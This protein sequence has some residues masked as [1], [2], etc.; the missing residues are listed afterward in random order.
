VERNSPGK[1][2]FHGTVDDLDL[3]FL[4]VD[5]RNAYGVP[6]NFLIDYV[7]KTE[8]RLSLFS[9]YK[10]HLSQSFARFFMKVGLPIDIDPFE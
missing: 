3:D 8:R 1:Q 4:V 5:F 10:E 9:P 6:Y 7:K 2:G